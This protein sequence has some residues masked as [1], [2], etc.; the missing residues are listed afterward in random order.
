MLCKEC[1]KVMYF[2][3]G[4]YMCMDHCFPDLS[5]KKEMESEMSVIVPKCL[6]CGF[7][8]DECNCKS[9]SELLYE[10]FC[11]NRKVAVK[12]TKE[13]NPN[14]YISEFDLIRYDECKDKAQMTITL[15]RNP[16][17]ELIEERRLVKFTGF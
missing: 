15:W 9:E 11:N 7:E 13:D 2:I 6:R 1:G 4:K 3:N 17:K 12:P 16:S 10:H 8:M 5:P 14:I